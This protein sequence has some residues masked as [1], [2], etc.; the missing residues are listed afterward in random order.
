[1]VGDDR[2]LTTL[3]FGDFHLDVRGLELRKGGLRVR[4]RRQPAQVLSVLARRPGEIV[5]RE[6]LQREIWGVGTFVDFERGLNNCIKQIRE[7]LNDDTESPKY[8]ETIPRQGYRFV[9][10][11]ETSAGRNGSS[12]AGGFVTERPRREQGAGDRGVAAKVTAGTAG[13]HKNRIWISISVAAVV[14]IGGAFAV[15]YEA[16][17]ARAQR[18]RAEAR[19][20]DVW[21]LANSLMFDVHDS[22]QNL[23]GS[24]PA[25]KL[26]VGR[27]IAQLDSLSHDAASDASLQRD[28]AMAYEKVGTVEGNPFG[29]NLGDT[30]GALDS[31]GKARAIRES[32]VKA[33]P[34]SID[35]LASLA[36]TERLVAA[37][38]VNRGDHDSI[39]KLEHAL[40]TMERASQVA[41]SNPGVLQELQAGYYLLAIMLDGYGD[42]HAAAGY[43]QKEVPIVEERLRAAP[44][45]LVLRRE[46]GAAEAK[47]GYALARLGSRPEGIAHSRRGIQMLEAMATDETDAESRRWLGMAHWMM[48][49][50]LMLDG[51]ARGALEHHQQQR[52]IAKELAAADPTNAVIQYDHSC[53]S[54]RVGN[55]MALAGNPSGGLAMLNQAARMFEVQLARDPAYTEPRFC[56]AATFIWMG[57]AFART[58]EM[59]RA[60]E[61]YQSG[62]T[63]WRE[64]AAHNKGT[65]IEADLALIDADIG[66]ADAKLGKLE[67]ASAQYRLALG[68]AEP[69]AAAN[70][71]ILETQYILADAYAGLGHVSQELASDMGRRVEQRIRDW[72]ESQGWYQRSL[73]VWERVQNPGART[74]VGFACGRPKAVAQELA[75]SKAALARLKRR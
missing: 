73:D 68:I 33:N 64:L 43:L 41:P 6:E 44:E 75:G 29:A 72:T 59:T 47:L 58:G 74:P 11:L 50:I 7:A 71:N 65:G 63:I 53:A 56:L 36:R 3:N 27:A 30:Q 57:E 37:V 18:V 13:V 15:V 70:P 51:D 8:V 10:R 66:R 28:L 5:T 2:N 55:A 48:G 16:Q 40:A 34:K 24:T 17:V 62:L 12:T 32:L 21:A 69:I 67:E 23:P 46:L 14:L 26:L 35:D 42:Y 61:N 52:R 45:D 49:D 54:A 20:K 60:V 22:I 4:L 38:L 31:Y 25:R 19:F 39:P 1:M 9:A